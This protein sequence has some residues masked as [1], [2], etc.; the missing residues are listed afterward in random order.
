MFP[1]TRKQE[2]WSLKPAT[3]GW[4][5]GAPVILNGN[6]SQRPHE[7]LT[8]YQN[9]ASNVEFTIVSQLLLYFLKVRPA[10]D[11]NFDLLPQFL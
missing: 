9:V 1:R 6:R 5:L 2:A 4:G 7:K 11:S 10:Y 8:F 3:R